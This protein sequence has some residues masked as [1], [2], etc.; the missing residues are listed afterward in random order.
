VLCASPRYLESRGPIS[1]PSDLEHHRC[2]IH[3]LY[4]VR[5]VWYFR[6]GNEISPVSVSGPINSNNS[7][8]LHTAAKDGMGVALLGSWAVTDDLKSGALVPL[9]QDWTGELTPEARDLYAIY[10]HSAHVSPTIRV[11][12]DF[13]RQHFGTPPYWDHPQSS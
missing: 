6:K 8:V 4:T 12:I 1:V 7:A 11:F 5:N 10:P 9:M 3:T 2:L 13:I